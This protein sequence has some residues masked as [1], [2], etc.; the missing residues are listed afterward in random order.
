MRKFILAVLLAA[1]FCHAHRGF[2]QKLPL[3]T[4]ATPS[5]TG[6]G[7]NGQVLISDGVSGFVPG[8]PIVS[9]NYANLLSA[10]PATGT[11]TG[12]PVRLSTFGA[13]GTL[14]VTFASITG[15][16]TSCTVQL[17]NVD[18]LGNA[19]NNSSA[20]A[21]TPANGTT[22]FAV[23]PI[24]A[25]QTAAQ[26]SAVYSCSGYPTGGT[27]SVDFVPAVSASIAGTVKVD[28][29][30]VTQ[31]VSAAALP[32]P[33]GAAT[34]ANQPTLVN[35]RTPV[36]PSGV[37]SPISAASLPLPSGAATA[38]KQPALGTAGT[39]ST[40][41]ISVQGVA[42]GTAVKVDG[43]GVTQPV[44]ASSLPLPTGAAT[45]AN[46]PTLVSGRTPVDPSGVTSPISAASLPLPAGA[47]QDA[48]L[49]GGTTK[50]INRG[51]A[52][53]TTTAADVTSTA[54]GANHQALDV[55]QY[56]ASGNQLGT[57]G[58]PVRT[59]PTGTTTQPV[60]CVSGCTAGGSFTDNSAFTAG[61]TADGNVGGVFN[62]GLAAVTSGNGAAA[63][64]TAQRGVHVN[65]RNNS[66]TEIGTSSTPIRTDPTGTTPEPVS[67]N[68]SWTVQP[69]NTAN[70]TPWLMA[71]NYSFVNL[72]SASSATTTATGS[73]V[74]SS[75]LSASGTLYVT[76]ASITGSP[77]ACTIQLIN[78]DSLG[79]SIN[80][81]PP[82]AVT[83]ANGTSTFS[84]KPISGLQNAAKM[85][86]TFACTTFPTA[87][88][89]SVDFAPSVAT[90]TA[91]GYPNI[92][93]CYSTNGRTATYTGQGSSTPLFSMRWAPTPS[94]LVALIFKVS[95][96]VETTTAATVV[97]PAERELI[98]S[99][100]YT[101]TDTGGTTLGANKLDPNYPASA[102][103]AIS[104]GNGTLTAGTRTLN[105]AP[106]A[107]VI[108]WLPLLMT[109]VDIG[110]ACGNAVAG[111]LV[112]WNCMGGM[113]PIDLWNAT[114][115]QNMP[116]VLR[117]NNGLHVR[118]GKDAQPTSAVQRTMVNVMW[119]E[120]TQYN[121][122]Q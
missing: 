49:T 87:G 122:A 43:S 51:G 10:R 17:K 37:T 71:D 60:N 57:S 84:I 106:Y 28:G 24:L 89:I 48:T 16:G 79:N 76:F 22:S 44:S 32:L 29:S 72:L 52:K 30:G 101:V 31:P 81:G 34:S 2:A 58:S 6:V 99:T 115:N 41:V 63:R 85:S 92:I 90:F 104:L 70:T 105:S 97:G 42:S 15:S 9:F 77:S 40:D 64:I 95:A 67:Q 117:N 13:N 50:A 74:R 103:A 54:S 116:I 8:D 39:P 93:G 98:G 35:G 62:D 110:G 111:T 3:A 113:G 59:D 18:S 120:A 21:V 27:L 5:V 14:Y 75:T 47:A 4:Q 78:F 96:N 121:A 109:G 11:V 94:T 69:G 107:S 114:N 55:A 68:G 108:S 38:A 1:S 36:D 56:D 83:V 73:A 102:M 80:N 86:A 23:S 88:T 45:S 19:I 119:C 46:Q 100:A 91:F 82:I 7:S 112:A 25:L 65:L 118:I 20:I 12:T 26:M 33:T 53:G 61:T 66:G